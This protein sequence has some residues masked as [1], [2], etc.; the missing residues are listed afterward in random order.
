MKMLRVW[1]HWGRTMSEALIHWSMF[2]VPR[3]SEHLA[4]VTSAQ[5]ASAADAW[6]CWTVSQQ[7][8]HKPTHHHH[9]RFYFNLI[10]CCLNSGSWKKYISSASFPGAGSNSSA[11]LASCCVKYIQRLSQMSHT[12]LTAFDQSSARMHH[13]GFMVLIFTS[14]R[15]LRAKTKPCAPL[16]N[17]MEVL[18]SE[19]ALLALL[20]HYMVDISHYVTTSDLNL[21]K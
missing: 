6:T 20:L 1:S 8:R 11:S 13:W 15:T 18:T 21:L 14:W 9:H 10:R 5:S 3:R 7:R 19:L 17:N 12:D 16:C 2:S 4:H